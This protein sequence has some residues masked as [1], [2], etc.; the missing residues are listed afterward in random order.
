MERKAPSPPLSRIALSCV[1]FT[2]LMAVVFPAFAWYGQQR[3]GADGLWAALVSFGICWLSAAMSLVVF[4]LASRMGQPLSGMLM[5]M[6]FRM[7]PPLAAC[8]LFMGKGSSLARAGV[9]GMIL[10]YYLV[11]LLA[12]TLLSLRLVSSASG[13]A[14]GSKGSPVG[15]G[16]VS[17]AS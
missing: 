17:G 6:F 16:P 4:G 1:W 5:G 11:A 2:L 3:S 9:A 10:V 7:G 14:G 13:K 12:E 15:A 8:L